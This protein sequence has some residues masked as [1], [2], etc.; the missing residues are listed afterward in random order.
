MTDLNISFLVYAFSAEIL[1]FFSVALSSMSFFHMISTCLG[2]PGFS[3]V[4]LNHGLILVI[5]WLIHPLAFSGPLNYLKTI[6]VGVVMGFISFSFL[7][8]SNHRPLPDV[9][10]LENHLLIYFVCVSLLQGERE[11]FFQAGG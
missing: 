3:A 7:F 10:C 8:L 6:K 4:F 1:G 9:L 2:F 5:S 11:E